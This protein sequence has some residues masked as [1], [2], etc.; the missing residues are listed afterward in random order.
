MQAALS[1]RPAWLGDALANGNAP[2]LLEDKEHQ[3]AEGYWPG[4]APRLLR[5][6]PC[7]P[8]AWP[9]AGIPRIPEQNLTHNFKGSSLAWVQW[10]PLH[11]SELSF[12]FFSPPSREHRGG[13]HQHHD[14]RCTGNWHHNWNCGHHNHE[15]EVQV[16]SATSVPRCDHANRAVWGKARVLMLRCCSKSWAY[17]IQPPWVFRGRQ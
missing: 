17:W 7:I 3:G 6:G 14:Q 12:A 13:S 8:S 5:P 10:M 11:V 4:G 16:Q 2:S 1:C 15:A 9:A